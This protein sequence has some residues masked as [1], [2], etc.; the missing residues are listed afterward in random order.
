MKATNIDQELSCPVCQGSGDDPINGACRRC[1]GEQ[2]INRY[3]PNDPSTAHSGNHVVLREIVGPDGA[4]LVE[5]MPITDRKTGGFNGRYGDW[6]P[7]DV[8][9]GPMAEYQPDTKDRLENKAFGNRGNADGEYQ[10]DG[11]ESTTGSTVAESD[12]RPGLP[13]TNHDMPPREVVDWLNA[14]GDTN[15]AQVIKKVADEVDLWR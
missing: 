14:R 11:E 15:T 4:L 9:T 6:T 2:R 7:D 5:K 12:F 3:G 13:T 1:E 8:M 10:L